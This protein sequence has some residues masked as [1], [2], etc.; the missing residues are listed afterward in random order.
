LASVFEKAGKKVSI[1]TR[2]SVLTVK[3]SSK[4]LVEY[5][6][7]H[8]DYDCKTKEKVIV[9]AEIPSRAFQ[10]GILA[11]IIDSDGH[12]HEHLGTEIKTV[13]GRIFKSMTA[14]LSALEISAKTKLRDSPSNS[15]SKKPRYEIYIPS[16][17]MKRNKSK[18]PSVKIARYLPKS[19]FSEKD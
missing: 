1:F 8:L 15:F 17:E 11:G 14:I 6:Q 12:V 3:V 7:K 2:G 10:Y 5:L 13:S 19:V 18:I 4:D 9:H 16:A